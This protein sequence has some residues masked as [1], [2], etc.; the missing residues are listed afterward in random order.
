MR[1][2]SL[3]FLGGDSGVNGMVW[4]GMVWY[5]IEWAGASCFWEGSMTGWLVTLYFSLFS[6]FLNIGQ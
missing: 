1:W 6:L 4:Y 5:V 3:I 2:C